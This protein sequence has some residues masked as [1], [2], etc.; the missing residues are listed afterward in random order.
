M[1]CPCAGTMAMEELPF[2]LDTSLVSEV[3]LASMGHAGSTMQ[4]IK[5]A[6]WRRPPQSARE[7]HCRTL[8]A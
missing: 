2:K 7:H 5:T 1:E 6:L 4:V 8:S 3:V